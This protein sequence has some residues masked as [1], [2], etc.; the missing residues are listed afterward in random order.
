MK[1]VRDGFRMIQHEQLLQELVH[2]SYKTQ[3]KLAEPT[4]CPDCG[5]V[6]HKGRWG[7]GTAPQGAHAA[8]CPACHRIHDAF[9]A[10]HVQLSG[11]Y[12]DQHREEILARVRHVEETEKK[13]H[14]LERIM[15]ISANGA[16]MVVTTTG[17]HLARRIGEAVHSAYKG[18]LEFHYNKQENLLRAHWKR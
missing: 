8:R 10:G 14:A 4:R 1:S 16:G 7:W 11:E 9:P 5:A 12:F 18:K 3:E 17:T 13:D 6:Y 2:D 15:E